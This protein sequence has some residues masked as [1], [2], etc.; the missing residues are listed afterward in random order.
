MLKEEYKLYEDD[1]K[2]WEN[3]ICL[4]DIE[5]ER[6]EIEKII[7]MTTNDIMSNDNTTLSRWAFMLARYG[8][9]LQNKEN[10]CKS[11]L[12]WARNSERRFIDNDKVKLCNW[13]KT[14]DLR[15]TRILF[16]TRR[17]D[18]MIQTLINICKIRQQEK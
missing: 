5:P 4:S 12:Q 9:F 8:F 1:L 7:E 16:L 15:L 18:L 17:I 3:T 2:K 10:K 6:S 13:V 14:I 11:F